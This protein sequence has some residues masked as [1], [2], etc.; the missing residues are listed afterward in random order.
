MTFKPPLRFAPWA[1][2]L[3]VFPAHA[4]DERRNFFNDPFVQITNSLRGCPVPA[5]PLY[6][7]DEARAEE[8]ARS[9]RGVSCHMA[10]RC[11]LP[12]AY[13]YDREIMP[14]VERAIHADGRF[15]NTS[16]WAY[17]QR[18]WVWLQGC[19]NSEAEALAAE[20]LVRNID[21]VEAVINELSVGVATR[22]RYEVAR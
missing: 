14:R 12:N 20:Q 5:G 1:L 19:V 16:I 8:H 9:Q 2:A 15:K 21:D 13:L 7:N 10:G 6:S 4:A 18:R 22:P 17:G 11:R 3:V